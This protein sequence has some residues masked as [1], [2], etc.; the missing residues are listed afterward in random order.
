PIAPDNPNKKQSPPSDKTRPPSGSQTPQPSAAV[1]RLPPSAIPSSGSVI[2]SQPVLP[3]RGNA[4]PALG[5]GGPAA[6]AVPGNVA[7]RVLQ[8][9]VGSE[10]FQQ[11][12]HSQEQAVGGWGQGAPMAH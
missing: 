8:H 5:S 7:E 3:D 9:H 12:L 11:F 6:P 4:Q 2:I 1:P 10:H